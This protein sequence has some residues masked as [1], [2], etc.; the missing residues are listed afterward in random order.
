MNIIESVNCLKKNKN[1]DSFLL[2][3]DQQK[4]FD[5]VN[6]KYLLQ[7]LRKFGLG[8]S[9]I[10]IVSNIFFNQEARIT[11]NKL[12]SRSFRL[13][14]GVRQGD[15]LSPILF[16]LSIEPLLARLSSSKYRVNDILDNNQAFA[17]D[18]TI[19]VVN[20]SHLEEIENTVTTYEKASNAKANLNKSVLIPL[21]EKA[22]SAVAKGDGVLSKYSIMGKGE[23]ITILG[24]HFNENLEM[25]QRTWTDLI[26]KLKKKLILMSTRALSLKGRSLTANSLLVSKIW[27]TSY[28]VPPLLKQVDEIQVLLNNWARKDSKTLPAAA[29][30][31][32]PIRQG[33]W[34]LTNMRAS[35]LARDCMMVNKLFYSDENWAR[36]KRE[37]LAR[38]QEKILKIQLHYKKTNWPTELRPRIKAWY[39]A[40]RPQGK[41]IQVK[42]IVSSLK[43]NVYIKK[44]WPIK[45]EKVWSDLN[46]IR[47]M[48]Q[49]QINMW[50]WSRQSLP[51]KERVWWS[52]SLD[53]LKCD[54]CP[55]ALQT[56][57]HFLFD[58]TFTKNIVNELKKYLGF[59]PNPTDYRDVELGT[60][61]KHV[62]MVGQLFMDLHGQD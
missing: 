55:N 54:W 37:D 9:L 41:D 52:S 10:K 21:T 39:T 20:S 46:S 8:E 2:Q 38:Y 5:R 57:D 26:G 6:H 27:H 36:N 47:L 11:N 40:G 58:C 15:P 60:L 19:L 12:L 4:A 45:E 1:E 32:L 50:R 48:P 61:N 25:H 51:L 30:I 34:N 59:I 44:H 53:S 56:H 42:G 29:I 13:N 28:I 17:D 3:L 24:F 16:A 43:K 31:Q 7:V 35:L 18:T 49:I 33:G 14:R 62:L 23:R 22:R